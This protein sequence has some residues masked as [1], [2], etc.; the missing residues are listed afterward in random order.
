MILNFF[1]GTTIR[2]VG[3]EVGKT[4]LTVAAHMLGITT[5]ILSPSLLPSPVAHLRNP[6]L[7][8]AFGFVPYIVQ[9]PGS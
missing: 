7:Q 9:L 2:C 8:F 6:C 1:I 4:W 5:E 3:L